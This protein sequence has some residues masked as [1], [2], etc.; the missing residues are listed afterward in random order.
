MVRRGEIL[1]FVEESPVAEFWG[2]GHAARD[3]LAHCAHGRPLYQARGPTPRVG[4]IMTTSPHPCGTFFVNDPADHEMT[5]LA[6]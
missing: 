5:V 3:Q 1:A 6:P 2:R 4:G